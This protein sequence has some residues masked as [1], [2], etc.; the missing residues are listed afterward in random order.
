M[1]A[2][3]KLVLGEGNATRERKERNREIE[4]EVEKRERLAAE[5]SQFN[6]VSLTENTLP[7][8]DAPKPITDTSRPVDPRGLR[9]RR[10]GEAIW[11]TR[12][13]GFENS[14]SLSI[15]R[16]TTERPTENRPPPQKNR[17]G[18]SSLSAGEQ[19]NANSSLPLCLLR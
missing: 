3:K 7:S 2:S 14:K 17:N 1:L 8:G 11:R 12:E 15:V 5:K 4:E 13:R 16:K 10:P 18:L 19:E 6:L 9:G